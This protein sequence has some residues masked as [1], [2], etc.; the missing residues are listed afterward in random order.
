MLRLNLISVGADPADTQCDGQPRGVG[1]N[2]L[3]I[4]Q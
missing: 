1:E 3:L 2:R 4:S